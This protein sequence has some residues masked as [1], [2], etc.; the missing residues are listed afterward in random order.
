MT[1]ND[2]V[3][4]TTIPFKT[5]SG[6]DSSLSDFPG[7]VLLIVNVASKCG[8]TPQYEGLQSLYEKYK[9]KGLVVIGFPANN[10]GAQEPGT[11]EEIQNFCSTN[12]HVTFP[13][14]SK[15]SVKGKD[16]HPLF[17]Y[18]TERS[19]IP[20]AI[21]WNFSKFL[22]D[23]HGRLVARFPSDI[24]PLDAQLTSKIESLF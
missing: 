4:F 6:S 21:K 16:K 7:K 13:M 11:D 2:S 23:R 5:I 1:A 14:M 12:Y 8:F 17:A 24:K 20:G 10:F 3:T 19:T 22:L 18:L 15:V 9:E